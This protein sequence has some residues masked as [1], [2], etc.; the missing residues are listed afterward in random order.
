VRSSLKAQRKMRE[1]AFLKGKKG[2]RMKRKRK[3][4]GKTGSYREN[5]QFY[6]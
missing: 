5:R 1:N 2:K 4:H 6:L 3:N